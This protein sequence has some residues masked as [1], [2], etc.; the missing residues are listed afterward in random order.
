LTRLRSLSLWTL[1]TTIALVAIGGFTRGSGSGYGCADRWP[2]CEGGALGGLLP[3]A[4]FHMIVEWTHRWIA[5]IVT[6]LI[7]VLVVE[8]WRH[9]RER[10]GLVVGATTALVVILAQAGLGAAVV[11]THLEAR[12]LVAVHLTVAMVILGLLAFVSV[13]ASRADRG[14]ALPDRSA[15]PPDAGWS[16]LLGAG[17]LGIFATIALGATVHDEY[18]GGWP[19]VEGGLIP[20]FSTSVVAIHFAHRVV[21]ALTFL[22]LVYVAISVIR[23]DRPRIEVSLVHAATALFA[24]NIGL[25]AAHVF[26]RVESTSLVVAHIL[27]AS[28]AWVALVGAASLARHPDTHVAEPGSSLGSDPAEATT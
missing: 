23:R 24:V 10:R 17:L 21:A 16:R 2:L 15:G 18:V 6:V 20:E 9:H 7:V 25:G 28:L 11:I 22:S 19:L 5:A 13:E 26:T 12:E 4:D 14:A 1:A 27:V 8:A 3:R